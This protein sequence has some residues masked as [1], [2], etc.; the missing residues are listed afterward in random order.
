MGALVLGDDRVRSADEPFGGL[1]VTPNP[2]CRR[3]LEFRPRAIQSPAPALCPRARSLQPLLPLVES[4]GLDAEPAIGE[5]A[6]DQKLI[7]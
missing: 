6:R 3:G 4:A 1:V 5:T 7:R 2:A